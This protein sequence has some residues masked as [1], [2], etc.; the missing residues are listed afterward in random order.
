MDSPAPNKLMNNGS[1]KMMGNSAPNT[2]AQSLPAGPA[3]VARLLLEGNPGAETGGN[4][5]GTG[6]SMYCIRC[7]VWL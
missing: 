2:P 5:S 6:T 3:S 7:S 4:G 1:L